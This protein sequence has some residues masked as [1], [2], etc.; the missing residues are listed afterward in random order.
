[1]FTARYGLYICVLSGSQNKQR[2]F[3]CTSVTDW[4]RYAR[5]RGFTARY[6]LNLYVYF[7]LILVFS[8][9]Y[10]SVCNRKVPRPAISTGFRGF[11]LSS[12]K[13]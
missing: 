10:K 1:V 2:V 12:S 8:A 11:R 13:Y 3:H 4:F 7:R 5:L 9:A 6:E